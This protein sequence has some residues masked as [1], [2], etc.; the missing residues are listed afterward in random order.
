MSKFIA[1]ALLLLPLSL[2][3]ANLAQ[4]YEQVRRVAQ[5]DPKVRAAYEA[6]DRK[7]AA[8]IVELDPLLKGYPLGKPAPVAKPTPAPKL[9]VKP[10]PKPKPVPTPKPKPTPVPAPKIPSTKHKVAPGE[11]LEGIAIFYRVGVPT[12]RQANPGV[13]LNH[14]QS[15]QVLFVP[16]K[17][18]LAPP[19][20]Q[21]QTQPR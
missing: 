14:L 4:R 6:A 11:T 8:K 10:T 13:S 16:K 18:T 15:G 5:R 20:K 19:P 2:P 21:P 9:V 12:I 17:A 7:L 3:A 1:L